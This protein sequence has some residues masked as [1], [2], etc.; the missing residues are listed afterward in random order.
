MKKDEEKINKFL[1]LFPDTLAESIFPSL[2]QNMIKGDD[3]I[4]LREYLKYVRKFGL[5]FNDKNLMSGHLKFYKEIDKLDTFI[6]ECFFR[7]NPKHHFL[8]LHPDVRVNNLEL[9]KKFKNKLNT[10]LEN[11]E[12]K[13]DILR[14]SME[15]YLLGNDSDRTKEVE[16]TEEIDLRTLD[17]KIQ[18]NYLVYK[19]K[20]SQKI[21][22]TDKQIIHFLYYKYMKDKDYCFKKEILAK[23]FATSMGNIKNR[24]SSINNEIKKLIVKGKTSIDDFIKNEP[25]RGYHLNPRFMI[26]FTK[27]K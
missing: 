22:N 4:Y 6:V 9:W 27:K 23:E 16:M 26:Q 24:I 15:E 12:E 19:K 21:N 5:S 3:L 20:K 10:L 17:I 11:T 1:A 18:G 8:V 25:K 14:K 13:Y 7:V 2:D